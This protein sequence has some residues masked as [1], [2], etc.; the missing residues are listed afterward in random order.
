MY[1]AHFGLSKP[2]FKITPDTDSFFSGGNRGPVLEALMYAIMQGEGII[3]VT[4]EVG[5]GKT[6]LCSMLQARLPDHVVT[7][8]IAN[9]SVSPDEILRAVAFELEIP[10][11]QGATRLEVMRL[12]QEFLVQR[13]AD[14]HRVVLF[15]EE[16]QTMPLDTLEEIRLLS[17]LETKTEK[18]LQIVLFGQPE[19]DENLSGQ[20]I[21]QLRDRI[22]HSFRLEPLTTE[23]VHEYLMFR[24]RA[25]GYKG[26]DL[27][28]KG[29]VRQIRNASAGLTRRVNLIADKTLLAAFAD[30]THTV[31]PG[32]VRSAVRD[33]AFGG[34]T[35]VRGSNHTKLAVLLFATA[36][37]S[38]GVTWLILMN[39][40]DTPTV[41]R[42]MEESAAANPTIDPVPATPPTPAATPAPPAAVEARTPVAPIAVSDP[43]PATADEN[44]SAPTNTRAVSRPI[45][46]PE[47]PADAQDPMRA[48][49]A[50]TQKWL[51]QAAPSA[52]TIQLLGVYSED[53]LRKHIKQISKL[54]EIND[55]FVYRTEA[56]GKPSYTLSFGVFESRQSARDALAKLEPSL[57]ANRPIVRSVSGIRAELAQLARH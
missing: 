12:L 50:A 53:Q 22:A 7:V 39:R 4:G 27:F 49:L 8:Y 48:R 10:V 38:A 14:G 31:T 36:A 35:M 23:E 29:V 41:S 6:M 15:V 13:H 1:Y 46:T 34:E 45:V 3:K 32:H 54:V 42:G 33:T 20:N 18:L 5:S 9:P 25:A 30:N 2:P 21:R 11:P 43:S 16:S 51:A 19:L 57:K 37:A 47:G 56:K 17:N 44:K 26:P 40:A 24:M 55:I 28:G 52:H